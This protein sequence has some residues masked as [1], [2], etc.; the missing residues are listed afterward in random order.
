MTDLPDDILRSSLP[1]LKESLARLEAEREDVDS[2]IAEL[3][4][5]IK[6]LS[7]AVDSAPTAK[8]TNLCEL[9]GQTPPKPGQRYCGPCRQIL[10]DRHSGDKRLPRDLSRPGTEQIGRPA[11]SPGS[12]DYDGEDEVLG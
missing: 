6:T 4:R 9:C 12:A 1:Y 10:K 8:A 11:L 2:R 7:S 5:T 3:A